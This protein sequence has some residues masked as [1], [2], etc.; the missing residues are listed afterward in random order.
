M[1]R[2]FYNHEGKIIIF[3]CILIFSAFMTL[4]LLAVSEECKIKSE[5]LNMEYEYSFLGGCRV[6]HNGK[7]IPLMNYRFNEEIE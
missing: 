7:L 3:V 5:G 4:L 6:K 2:F 1:D